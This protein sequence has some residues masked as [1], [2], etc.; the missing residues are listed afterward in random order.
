MKDLAKK[1][2]NAIIP[3]GY[4]VRT[5]RLGAMPQEVDQFLKG[6]GFV[7]GDYVKLEEFTDICP[8]SEEAAA[9]F[10]AAVGEYPMIHAKA[11]GVSTRNIPNGKEYLFLA[12]DLPRE[13]APD[14][15]PPGEMKIYV[16]AL[17]G[18]SPVFTQ[19]VR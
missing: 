4:G 12:V 8:V 3:N 11:E 18:E 14:M 9:I 19:V 13:D 17:D 6:N 7:E 1:Q 10:D 5:A 15:P 16:T 2:P